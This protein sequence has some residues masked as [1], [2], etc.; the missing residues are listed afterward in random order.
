MRKQG[1]RKLGNTNFSNLSDIALGSQSQSSTFAQRIQFLEAK[2]LTPS[3]IEEAMRQA[4]LPQ[5]NSPQYSQ[6]GPY[7]QYGPQFNMMGPTRPPLDW[8]DYFVSRL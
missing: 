7:P 5:N 2:G 4:A 3:E 1:Q 8:R 6:Y